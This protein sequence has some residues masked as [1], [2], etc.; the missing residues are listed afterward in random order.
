MSPCRAAHLPGEHPHCQPHGSQ[1]KRPV[2]GNIVSSLPASSSIVGT[3]GVFDDFIRPGWPSADHHLLPG[4]VPARILQ[5]WQEADRSSKEDHTEAGMS[6]PA[7][8]FPPAVLRNITAQ[9]G[10]FALSSPTW[11]CGTAGATTSGLTWRPAALGK[12]LHSCVLS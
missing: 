3:G 9:L 4:P 5:L 2:P 1:H 6:A 8:S 12:L 11:V 7:P 10:P